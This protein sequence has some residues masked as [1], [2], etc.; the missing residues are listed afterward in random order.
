MHLKFKFNDFVG[1]KFRILNKINLCRL[2]V[3]GFLVHELLIRN[4]CRLHIDT[5]NC[6]LIPSI[7]YPTEN[8]KCIFFNTRENTSSHHH[9]SWQSIPRDEQ[10]LG[11][12]S[13]RQSVWPRICK[14]LIREAAFWSFLKIYQNDWNV[15]Q[16]WFDGFSV[17][18]C[19][20]VCL[21]DVNS[22]YQSLF[23]LHFVDASF[24]WRVFRQVTSLNGVAASSV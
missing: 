19:V 24:L 2:P 6:D 16:R 22:C 12:R 13:V 15:T 21:I 14:N 18:W 20:C 3:D 7:I 17:L 11:K 9:V 8:F 5:F 23:F 10:L 1:E 4:A